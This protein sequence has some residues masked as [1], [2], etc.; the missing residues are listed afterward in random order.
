MQGNDE[1]GGFGAA[2]GYERTAITLCVQFHSSNEERG[3]DNCL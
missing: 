1:A 2:E 3:D